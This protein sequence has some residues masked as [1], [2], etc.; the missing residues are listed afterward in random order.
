VHTVHDALERRANDQE[1]LDGLQFEAFGT[2]AD[3]DMQGAGLVD[4]HT[5]LLVMI[6]R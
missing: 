5:T 3:V 1:V 6:D 4:D 2:V